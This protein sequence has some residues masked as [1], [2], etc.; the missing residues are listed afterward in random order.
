M[1]KTTVY[2][3][4]DIKSALGKLAT[5]RGLSEAEVIRQAL[6]AVT[7]E[8]VPPRPRAPLFKS[9][10]PLLAEQID[11]ALKGFGET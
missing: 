2:I 4:S 1:Q 11:D 7:A 9:G 10:R 3:P 8:I 5:A 6:R